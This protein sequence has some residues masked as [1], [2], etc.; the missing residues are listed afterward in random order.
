MRKEEIRKQVIAQLKKLSNEE[1]HQVEENLLRNLISSIYWKRATTIGVTISR[2]FEWDTRRIIEAGWEQGKKI[3]VPK[4]FPDDKKLVFYQLHNFDELE[5][6]YYNLLEPKPLEENKVAKNLIDLVIVPGIVFNLDG[7]RIG[8]GGGYYD[9]FL[10]NYSG[11]TL[12]LLSDKQIMDHI[13][14]E[15]H[16]IAV[17]HLISESGQLK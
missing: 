7:Y 1:N 6:V 12:S 16:D 8:F 3:V 14:V 2:G 10:Q 5:S 17:H 13:P 9:R 15:S 4:C 11:E